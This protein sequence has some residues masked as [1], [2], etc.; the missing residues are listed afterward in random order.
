[1]LLGLWLGLKICRRR[2]GVAVESGGISALGVREKCNCVILDYFISFL[3]AYS[4]LTPHKEVDDSL[5]RLQELM[6]LLET[7]THQRLQQIETRKRHIGLDCGTISS[8]DRH[9]RGQ[10][11]HP[12][13]H[14]GSQGCDCA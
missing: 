5:V 6:A 1:M 8:G 2:H 3:Y 14:G 9:A 10:T 11:T 7:D 12:A 4:T 13:T